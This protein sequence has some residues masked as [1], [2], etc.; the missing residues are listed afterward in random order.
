M[1]KVM[2]SV[3]AVN[4]NSLALIGECLSSLNSAAGA[5]A[6]EFLAVDSGSREDEAEGLRKLEG[7]N[8]RVILCK[9]NIGYARAVNV[10]LEVARG[11]VILITNPDVVYLPGSVSRMIAALRELPLCGAVGPRTWWDESATFLLPFAELLTPFRILR[12]GLAGMS[13]VAGKNILRG[14]VERAL[15]C[16]QADRPL[17]QEMLAGACIMTTRKVI[18]RVGGFDEAFPLYFEDT[19]WC[20][21]TG[22]AG[23]R[24]YMEPRANIIH[25]YNQSA[26]EDSGTSWGKYLDSQERYL[27]KHFGRAKL[28]MLRRLQRPMGGLRKSPAHAEDRGLLTEPPG[29][30][31][32]EGAEKLFLLSPVDT[33]MPSAGSF[34]GGDSFRISGDLWE[35]LGRGRYYAKALRLEGF[36][37][38]GSW[39]WMKK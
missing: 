7:Q 38:C 18:D 33:F 12:D 36:G 16:W 22:R 6:F 27:R 17:P 5:D 34:F 30:A 3:I 2:L 13:A 31:F 37:D 15:L 32:E 25:Y 29:F 4:H 9:E 10:G 24:L 14:W 20:L 26:K 35:R 11:E 8:V 23:Y 28:F 1:E 21:R 39:T 19:D